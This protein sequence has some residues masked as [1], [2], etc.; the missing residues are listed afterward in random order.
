MLNHVNMS[1]ISKPTVHHIP[2]G[3]DTEH[4]QPLNSQDSRNRYD[5]ER[6]STVILFIASNIDDPTKGVTQLIDALN[7]L[8]NKSNITLLA[9][10]DGDFPGDR[11]SDSFT[12]QNPGYINKSEI[13]LAYS[14]ADLC[15]IPSRA[16]SFGLVATESMACG[17]P[18]VAFNIGGLAEQITEKTGW[19]VPPENP[20]AL[21][22]T[23]Q[24]AIDTIPNTLM[25]KRARQRV[26][27]NYDIRHCVTQYTDLYKKIFHGR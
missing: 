26:L 18:V 17:T 24:E 1:H 21:G 5:I 23:I 3:I 4:Y 10:G 15:V 19:L 12:V 16:E 14:S 11:L 25:S 2:D 22:K 6:D 9:I 7:N 8:E 27:N 20:E 13:P